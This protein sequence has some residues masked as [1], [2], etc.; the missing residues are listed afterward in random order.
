MSINISRISRLWRFASKETCAAYA[1]LIVLFVVCAASNEH[2]RSCG[3]LINITRQVSY[4][5]I[6]ALG[7]TLIIISGGIDLSVG[8]LLAL[9]GVISIEVLNQFADPIWGVAVALAAALG[10]GALGGVINGLLSGAFK[11][12]AFIVTLGT[13]SI[14]RSLALYKADAGLISSKNNLYNQLGNVEFLALPLP[15]WIMLIFAVLLSLLLNKMSFGRHILAVGSSERV[16]LYAGLKIKRIIFLTYLIGGALAGVGAFLL[17]AR[18][19]SISSSNS[20]LNYELDAIAAVIIGGTAMSGGRG[21]IWGTM[22]GIF[23]LGI[24]SNVLDMWGISSNLQGL[25][26]GSVIIGAVLIQKI[27]R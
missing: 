20:G 11:I 19:G 1:A 14:F 17:G 21:S 27:R 22:A 24:V 5:G 25:I 26:K 16:A 10:V 9:C 7:M 23:V 4:S 15:F 18:L 13:M 6:L 8:S 2:F 3:N 12:P